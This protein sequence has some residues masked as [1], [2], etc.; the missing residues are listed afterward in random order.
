M[1]DTEKEPYIFIGG[2]DALIFTGTS[3]PMAIDDVRVYA[4]ILSEDQLAAIRDG[5]PVGEQVIG[6][7]EKNTASEASAPSGTAA[8]AF[9]DV[10]RDGE[11]DAACS[12]DM[13]ARLPGDQYAC[14]RLPGDQYACKTLTDDQYNYAA[15]PGDQYIYRDFPGAQYN[16]EALPG[17]QYTCK[18]LPGDQYTC[19][20]LPGD[21]YDFAAL[22][23]D[24]YD[25][26][27]LVRGLEF[28][29]YAPNSQPATQ[30]QAARSVVQVADAIENPEIVTPG[31]APE[32]ESDAPRSVGQLSDRITSPDVSQLP[33]GAPDPQYD[34]PEAAEE[35]ALQRAEAEQA[36][37]V[38]DQQQAL[39]GTGKP[40][41]VG[42]RQYSAI[43]GFQVK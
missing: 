18:Q 2:S 3:L 28:P 41:P 30:Q 21:Q 14:K 32:L 11:P 23:G 15:L 40:R 42:D 1:P 34:S 12:G 10:C 33:T 16:P 36:Q 7:T 27:E 20:E 35:A 38:R 43:S 39:E 17:D 9:P 8:I 24:Q 13:G 25:P 37:E 19:K 4:G 5:A 26:R 22:P 6:K 31:I 29:D